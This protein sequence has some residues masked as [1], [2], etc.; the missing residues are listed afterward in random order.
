VCLHK[1][2]PCVDTTTLTSGQ[3]SEKKTT[4]S[5]FYYMVRYMRLLD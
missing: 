4:E 2:I 1:K 5:L 3:G